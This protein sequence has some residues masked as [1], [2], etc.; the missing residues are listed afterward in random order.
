ML[1]RRRAS[2]TNAQLLPSFVPVSLFLDFTTLQKLLPS[3]LEAAVRGIL[4]KQ[5]VWLKLSTTATPALGHAFVA[6]VL[7][8]AEAQ[9]LGSQTCLSKPQV[10]RNESGRPHSSNQVTG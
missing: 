3:S 5:P 10:G 7:R 4:G 8:L 1:V 6:G 2:A 9:A